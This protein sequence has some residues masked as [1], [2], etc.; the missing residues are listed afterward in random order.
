VFAQPTVTLSHSSGP[1]TTKLLV[2]GSGYD[3]YSAVDIYFD[4]KDEALAVTDGNGAFGKIGITVPGSA[5]PGG[6]WITGVERYK[7]LAGQSHFLVETDWAEFHFSPNLDGFNP[8]EN[9]LNRANVSRMGV[10]WNDVLEGDNS[11]PVIADGIVYVGSGT[12]L[13]AL[14]ART[15]VQLWQSTFGNIDS[16]SSP[17]VANGVIYVGSMDGSLYA[18]S[19]RDGTLLWKYTTPSGLEYSPA[20]ANGVVY[21]SSFDGYLYALNARNGSLLWQTDGGYTT[22]PATANGIVYISTLVVGL[23]AL[24]ANTGTVLWRRAAW[25]YSSPAVANGVVYV[26]SGNHNISAFNAANGA[27]LCA[28]A[29]GSAV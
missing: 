14:N 8:Y 25:G 18:L 29:T 9:V 17:A 13:Y 21:A 24:D 22:S 6:H 26:G 28:Y 10:R 1:P 20:V 19:A 23:S 7:G 15:G 3:P 16:V 12:R 5:K 2:S 4:A 11:G 27:P